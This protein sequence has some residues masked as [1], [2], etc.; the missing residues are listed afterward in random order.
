MPTLGHTLACTDAYA[1]Y[2][3]CAYSACAQYALYVRTFVRTHPVLSCWAE[4]FPMWSYSEIYQRST[5]KLLVLPLF[6]LLFFRWLTGFRL[7][8]DLPH[9]F[10]ISNN[11][12]GW[13]LIVCHFFRSTFAFP[14]NS[15]LHDR[16]ACKKKVECFSFYGDFEKKV[17]K[18]PE[19]EL[20]VINFLAIKRVQDI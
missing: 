9:N 20:L 1:E 19:N 18:R 2:A 4:Y 5:V 17:R 7:T 11:Y 10:K 15:E 16:D 12:L 6:Y 13:H 3:Q 8:S 14:F